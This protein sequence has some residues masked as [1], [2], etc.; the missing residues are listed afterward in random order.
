MKTSHEFQFFSEDLLREIR[1]RF[2]YLDSD[3]LCGKRI[4]L[5]SASGSLRLAAAVEALNEQSKYPDQLGRANASSRQS[6]EVMAQGI[7]DVKLFLGTK[8]GHV[9]P[10][11]SSTHAVFRIV[12]AVLAAT[13]GDNVVTTDLEH[14]CVYDATCQFA[15][16]YGKEWRVAQL[17]PASGAVSP[18]SILEKVDQNTDFIGMIHGSNITGSVLD[19]KTVVRRARKINP[20]IYVLAD[21]VQY[22]PHAPV[23]VDDLDVDAYVFGPYKTFCV[24]GIGFAYLSERLAKLRHW[25]LRGNPRNSWILGSPEEATYRSWSAVVEYLCWLGNHFTPSSDRRTQLTAA[26][27]ASRAHMGA[28][29]DRLL[30]GTSEH[31]GLLQMDHVETHGVSP[32]A[33]GRLCLVLFSLKRVNSHIAV[34]IY[35]QAGLRLHNRTMDAYSRHNLKALGLEEGVRLSACHYNTPSEIDRFLEVTSDIGGMSEAQL[36]RVSTPSPVQ[37]HGEG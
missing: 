1:G 12:N 15:E 27:R 29:L 13:P 11:M 18:D 33:A 36:K 34:E 14:P 22:A 19:V 3:P 4:W 26:M 20:E 10:A 31:S 25:G 32:N 2:L 8:A 37:G 30:K 9:M 28:L 35:N 23:D 6:G 21:G 24:K 16:I 17:D 7:E 5:E